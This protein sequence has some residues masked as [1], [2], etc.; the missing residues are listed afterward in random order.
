ML[1]HISQLR[2]VVSNRANKLAMSQSM[3]V[4]SITLLLAAQRPIVFHACNNNLCDHHRRVTHLQTKNN[5]EG[6]A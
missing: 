6:T 2:N 1:S 4:H 3:H 5:N